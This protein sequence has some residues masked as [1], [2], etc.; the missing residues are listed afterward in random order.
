ME[1]KRSLLENFQ[2][3]KLYYTILMEEFSYSK[4]KVYTITSMLV[5]KH[6]SPAII[7]LAS[8]CF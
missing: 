6:R 5:K 3:K 1:K 2:E 7:S 8:H 4:A